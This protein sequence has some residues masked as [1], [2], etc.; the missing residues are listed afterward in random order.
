MNTISEQKT[1]TATPH[2][3][4]ATDDGGT[5]VRTLAGSPSLLVSP[6]TM[7]VTFFGYCR[8]EG[9]EVLCVH[10]GVAMPAGSG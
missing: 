10:S 9:F 6:P 5:V 7:V 2:S 1:T 4:E 3:A 8:D